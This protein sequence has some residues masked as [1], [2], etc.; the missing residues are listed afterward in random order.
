MLRHAIA[1]SRRY[2]KASHDVVRHPRLTSD[3][4]ILLLYVQGL[5][6]ELADMPLGEHARKLGITGR[7]YQKAKE[8][9]VVNGFLHERR[10]QGVHGLWATAQ[11]LSNVS[12]TPAEAAAVRQGGASEVSVCPGAREPAVGQPDVGEPAVGGPAGRVVGGQ[13]PVDEEREKNSPHPPSEAK[14][15]AMQ[16]GPK[17]EGS[18]QEGEPEPEAPLPPHVAEG[19]RVL[20]SLRHACRE[21]YLGVKEARALAALAAEWLRRGVTAAQLRRVLTSELPDGGVRSAVGFL[22]YRLVHKLPEEPQPEAYAPKP[23]A[24]AM[25]PCAGP[26]DEH[27]FRPL[28]D[29]ELCGPC[30][31]AE[32]RRF[33]LRQRELAE[34]QPDPLPWRE[35]FAV[36]NG[37]RTEPC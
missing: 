23:T 26:G 34:E 27:L 6:D 3:A 13:L 22:R 15:G 35:R 5:P 25:I 19:E 33:W 31:R 17:Q 36:V 4:K 9:L 1:P 16:E 20:L 10:E 37:P 14:P 12:L 8:L 21:L 29:E 18:K 30:G 24:A 11:L 28:R 7:A 32:A 2:T